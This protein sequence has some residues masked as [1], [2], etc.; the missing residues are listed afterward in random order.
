[1]CPVILEDPIEEDDA[2]VDSVDAMSTK[3]DLRRPALDTQPTNEDTKKG[4][5]FYDI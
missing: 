3:S 1:M 5:F 4:K 2:R